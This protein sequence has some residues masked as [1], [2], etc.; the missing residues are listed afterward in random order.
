MPG[1]SDIW[2]SINTLFEI[3]LEIYRLTHEDENASAAAN[4]AAKDTAVES[5]SFTNNATLGQ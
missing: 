2:G 1:Q 4:N 3:G 5:V